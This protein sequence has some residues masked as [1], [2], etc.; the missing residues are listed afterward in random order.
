MVA[1]RV[2]MHIVELGHRCAQD[3]IDLQSR[4]TNRLVTSSVS[5]ICSRRCQQV[6]IFMHRSRHFEANR[7]KFGIT[8]FILSCSIV[9]LG[10]GF[11]PG[12]PKF[13]PGLRSMFFEDMACNEARASL[14][15]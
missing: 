13:H 10:S 5:D 14:S 8:A 12:G 11:G 7:D 15:L 1:S 6:M 3:L 2:T 4:V 9:V